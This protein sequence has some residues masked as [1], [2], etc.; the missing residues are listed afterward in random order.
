MGWSDTAGSRAEDETP[1]G[2]DPCIAISCPR[3]FRRGL[4]GTVGLR[5]REPMK[6]TLFRRH[7]LTALAVIA[8]LPVLSGV[9]PVLDMAAEDTRD[10]IEDHHHP[11]THGL[12]HDHLIC[13]QQQASQWAPASALPGSTTVRA[14]VVPE[15]PPPSEAPIPKQGALSPRPRAP[16]VT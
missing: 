8:A 9:I 10:G 1:R 14:M 4:E 16:P 2:E 11:G 15:L 13:I 3:T 5:M 6:R 7:R 12:P